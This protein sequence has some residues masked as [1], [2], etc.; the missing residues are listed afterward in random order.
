MKEGIDPLEDIFLEDIARLE[1]TY[2]LG[3]ICHSLDIGQL[4]VDHLKVDIYRRNYNDHFGDMIDVCLEDS[5]CSP[6]FDKVVC[7]DNP[8]EGPLGNLDS[9]SSTENKIALRYQSFFQSA[10]P[11]KAPSTSY[12]HHL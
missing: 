3:G 6:S 2:L 4:L 5:H 12:L 7:L 11:T 10:R 8:D 9:H 1:D